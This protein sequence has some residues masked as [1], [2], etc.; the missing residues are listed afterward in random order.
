MDLCQHVETGLIYRNP[1]PHVRSEHAYFPSVAVLPDGEML[2]T[3]VL[4]EA[5]EAVNLRTHLFRSKDR[6]ENWE[7]EGP[8]CAGTPERLTSDCARLT[9]LPG[10]GLAVFM[11]R[12]D[13]SDHPEE[14]LTNHETLGFVP[15][16]LLLL[17]SEDCGRTWT[18]P[19]PIDPPLE[20]PSFEMCCAITVLN[21][22]RWIIPTQTWPGWDGECPNGI[23]MVALVSRDEGRTWPEYMDVM[24]E[25]EREVYFW[26]SKIVELPDGRLLA[27]AWVYDDDAGAD[28]PNHYAISRDG[29]CSW[30]APASTGLQGQTLTP[31]VLED[32]RILCVYRRMDEPGLWANLARLDGD[33]WINECQQPLWGHEAAGLTA[34]T[35]D[36][37][38]NFNVLRFGAPCLTRLEEDAIYLAFWCYEDCVSNI[39]WFKFSV[40]ANTC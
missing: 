23:R 14:G 24:H 32:G 6:G 4:G 17:R 38:H 22:G 9:A 1:K 13:R 36:M 29:G 37:A 5:F 18:D 19:E 3:V 33:E 15:T 27:T 16:E 35:E 31:L 39:R 30:S 21:D 7:H 40:G 2:A 34:S 11:I 25:P 12:H 20:G 28:R 8:L 10:G 26:E